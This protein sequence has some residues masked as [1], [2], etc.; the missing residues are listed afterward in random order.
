MGA[1][2]VIEL[3]RYIV[4]FRRI[5]R[6]LQKTSCSDDKGSVFFDYDVLLDV[7]RHLLM[8]L[9]FDA[10]WYYA[11]YPDVE[12]Y[13]RTKRVFASPNLHFRLV[14]YFEGR[15]PCEALANKLVKFP[16]VQ[17]MLHVVPAREGLRCLASLA[18]IKALIARFLAGIPVNE[19]WYFDNYPDVR[20]V[21]ERDSNFTANIHFVQNGYFESRLPFEMQVD[22]DWYLKAYPDVAE[23]VQKSNLPSGSYHYVKYGYREGRMPAHDIEA[24]IL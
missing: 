19:R 10:E 22:E 23:Q 15:M 13:V 2:V 12:R 16:E 1:E 3:P 7:V 4:P 8:A 24:A 20:A 6:V 17:G 21:A 18:E 5:E 9:P 14:G 11:Q